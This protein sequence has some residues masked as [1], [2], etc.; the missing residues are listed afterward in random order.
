MFNQPEADSSHYRRPAM[1][2]LTASFPGRWIGSGG[3]IQRPLKS[4]E[5]IPVDFFFRFDENLDLPKSNW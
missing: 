2:Y 5:V 1:K 4:P 3:F